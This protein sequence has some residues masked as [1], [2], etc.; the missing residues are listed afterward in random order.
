[1][2][3]LLGDY[4]AN[5]AHFLKDLG[6]KLHVFKFYLGSALKQSWILP[7]IAVWYNEQVSYIYIPLCV[8]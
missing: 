6:I 5:A 3:Y 1:M 4:R 8:P 2:V 7:D